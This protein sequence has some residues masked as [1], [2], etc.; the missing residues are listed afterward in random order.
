MIRKVQEKD[1][2]KISNLL[3]Q[4]DMV[5]NKIRPDLFK[6]PATKYSQEELKTIFKDETR[7]I[8]VFVNDKD[9][10]QGYIFCEIRQLKNDNILRNIKTLY[11]DDLCI[12]ENVRGQHIG[13]QLYDYV[14]SFAKENNFYNIT[15]N[16]WNGNDNAMRFY[17]KC[18]MKPQKTT[19]EIIL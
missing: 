15:L 6:C 4:V 19:M 16:V 7:L 9:I 18:G 13:K 1:L 10:V 17:K 2:D 5:H 3:L 11:I 12:D 14:V 8:F